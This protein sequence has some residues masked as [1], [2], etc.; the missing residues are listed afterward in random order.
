MAVKAVAG[1][2]AAGQPVQTAVHNIGRI[3]QEIGRIDQEGD[4]VDIQ[5]HALHRQEL[6]ARHAAAALELAHKN[7]GQAAGDEG[8]THVFGDKAPAKWENLGSLS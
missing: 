1:S 2:V 8:I 4:G 3:D 6:I 7:I 5:R